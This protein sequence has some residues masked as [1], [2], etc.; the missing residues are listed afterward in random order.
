MKSSLYNF[1][2]HL[3]A[4][5]LSVPNIFLST[6]FVPTEKSTLH[7]EKV[8]TCSYVYHT[9]QLSEMNLFESSYG[10]KLYH[11]NSLPHVLEHFFLRQ[12]GT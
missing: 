5:F 12:N 1:L 3:V 6:L 9:Y 7:T 10:R 11:L 2:Q 4:F 8:I